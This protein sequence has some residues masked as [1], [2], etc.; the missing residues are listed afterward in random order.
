MYVGTLAV[1]H[2]T[3]YCN[4]KKLHY[5]L[6]IHTSYHQLQYVYFCYLNILQTQ[7][8]FHRVYRILENNVLAAG[9]KNNSINKENVSALSTYL[10]TERYVNVYHKLGSN[11]K[12]YSF[13]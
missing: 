6:G 12:A 7:N 13:S 1:V 10:L 2:G 3:L 8:T 4:R 5:H 11:P 9:W